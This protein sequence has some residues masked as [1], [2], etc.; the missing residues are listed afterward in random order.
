MLIL[1]YKYSSEAAE[2]QRA[3]WEQPATQVPPSH[4]VRQ[5]LAGWITMTAA[6]ATAGSTHKLTSTKE[7]R[8][9]G[10]LRAAAPPAAAP[11]AEETGQFFSL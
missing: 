2:Q 10:P 3:C 8:K 1:G 11:H 4:P 9:V 6:A 7:E 5:A